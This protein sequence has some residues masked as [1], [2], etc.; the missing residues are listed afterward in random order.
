VPGPMSRQQYEPLR[1]ARVA[2][3]IGVW[4]LLFGVSLWGIGRAI[5]DD[6]GPLVVPVHPRGSE[7]NPPADITDT[8]IVLE[9]GAV[10]SMAD[11]VLAPLR[12]S[13]TGA[14]MSDYD[15]RFFLGQVA[16]ALAGQDQKLV[17]REP[18]LTATPGDALGPS[19]KGMGWSELAAAFGH[20]PYTKPESGG[21]YTG[22]HFQTGG[23]AFMGTQPDS[24]ITLL[25]PAFEE[26]AGNHI[27]DWRET[28][29]AT[30]KIEAAEKASSGD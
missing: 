9:D 18:R 10:V 14:G 25:K 26:Y 6:E 17:T 19:Y 12:R 8:Y 11:W 27:A 21:A 5:A 1:P 13:A 20:K 28:G 7:A 2:V 24:Q 22:G 15:N 16:R 29:L 23:S 30:Q 3:R 4:G